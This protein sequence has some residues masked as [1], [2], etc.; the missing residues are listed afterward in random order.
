MTTVV[1]SA[2][3]KSNGIVEDY[4]RRKAKLEGDLEQV[5]HHFKYRECALCKLVWQKEEKDWVSSVVA[6][7][8]EGPLMICLILFLTSASF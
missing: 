5:F 8:Q 6:S 1:E 4:V 7:P 3:T 2:P